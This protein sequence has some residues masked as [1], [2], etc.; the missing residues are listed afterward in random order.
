MTEAQ[1][2]AIERLKKEWS[3]VSE[4]TAMYWDKSGCV[5]VAVGYSDG[6]TGMWIGIE[7]DGYTHT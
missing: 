2:E 5:M 6:K 7:T 3:S 4:P 1:K